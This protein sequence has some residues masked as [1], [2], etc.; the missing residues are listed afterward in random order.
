MNITLSVKFDP[1]TL[2]AISSI[3]SAIAGNQTAAPAAKAEAPAKK[4]VSEEDGPILWGNHTS[5]EYGEVPNKEGFDA[6]KKA[7]KGVVRL[8]ATQFK[9][10]EAKA[11]AAKKAEAAAKKG[12]KAKPEKKAAAK[13]TETS[14]SLDDLKKAFGAYLPSDLDADERTERREFVKAI[15]D[16]FGAAKV[17]A[18]KEEH[19]ALA[20]EL[21]TRRMAGEDVDP[22]KSNFGDDAYAVD[23]EESDDDMI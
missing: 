11:K 14:A 15:L 21:V 6:L 1:E 13:K 16:R 22:A 7:D 10:M 18:M 19:W 8:T 17:T 2:S 3:A 20:I 12:E 23:A 5:G 4:A 9:E